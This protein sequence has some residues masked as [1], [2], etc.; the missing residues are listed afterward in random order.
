MA[1]RNTTGAV[2]EES[3][4]SGAL[5]GQD[6]SGKAPRGESCLP[7][8]EEGEFREYGMSECSEGFLKG[9]KHLSPASFGCSVSLALFA[10]AWQ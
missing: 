7:H 2:P 1:S 4:C 5:A 10:K 6:N 9:A 8:L 3:P